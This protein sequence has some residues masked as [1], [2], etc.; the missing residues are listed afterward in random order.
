MLRG[1]PVVDPPP[2]GS[3]VGLNELLGCTFCAIS[4]PPSG[5]RVE[6]EDA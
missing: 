4:V 1:R 3:G 5:P 6:P 2:T